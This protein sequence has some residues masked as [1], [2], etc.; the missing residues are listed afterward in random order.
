MDK[1]RLL[2]KLNRIAKKENLFFYYRFI[3]CKE[4]KWCYFCKRDLNGG[5]IIINDSRMDYTRFSHFHLCFKC[6]LDLNKGYKLPKDF[7]K[8]IP[9]VNKH[10][11]INAL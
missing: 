11:I 10:N 4:E 1:E 2:R 9:E 3:K 8:L 5:E 7:I 6:F